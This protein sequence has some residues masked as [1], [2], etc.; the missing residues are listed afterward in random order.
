MKQ[1]DL[2][3]QVAGALM[4]FGATGIGCGEPVG[5]IA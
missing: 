2:V 3:F 1:L 4:F 5:R